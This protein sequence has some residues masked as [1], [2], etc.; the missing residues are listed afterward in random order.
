MATGK[1]SSTSTVKSATNSSFVNPYDEYEDPQNYALYALNYAPKGTFASDNPT[2]TGGAKTGVF[3]YL[4]LVLGSAA[5]TIQSIADLKLAQKGIARG[6]TATDADVRLAEI[7]A[8]AEIAAAQKAAQ[9]AGG[10]TKNNST[11][12][13]VGGGLLFLVLLYLILKASKKP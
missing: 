8:R 3:D 13:Y 2:A 11:L 9:D 10:G 6:T 5:P 7:E 12:Y 4:N 1:N